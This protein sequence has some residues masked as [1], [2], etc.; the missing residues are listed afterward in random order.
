M[1]DHAEPF[2]GRIV[3]F[4]RRRL[5]AAGLVGCALAWPGAARAQTGENVL[6]VINTSQPASVKVGE[7]YATARRVP[8]NNVVRISAGTAELVSREDYERTIEQ[9]IGNWLAR[10]SLQ[11]K[12]LYLV[13]AKGVPLRISGTSGRD[14][15]E[16]SVDSELTLLYRKLAGIRTA[17]VGRVENPY[18]LN[19][20][21]LSEAKPFTRFVADIYLVTR[22]DGFTAEDAIK[23]IDRAQAPARNGKI[24]LDQP[25]E[26]TE[27]IGDKWVIEAGDRIK[28]LLGDRLVLETTPAPASSAAPV[29]GFFSWGSNDPSNQLRRHNLRFAN[30]AI[31]ATFVSTD[32]RT[33]VEPAD[34]WVPGARPGADSESLAA[35]LVREG[36]TGVVANVSE[37]YLEATARPQI[38]FPAYLTGFNLAESFYLSMPYLGW[39]T[40]V[41][42]DPLCAP[43]QQTPLRRADIDKGMDAET[44]LPALF[45]ERQLARLAESGLN[46]EGLKI[47]LRA[48]ARLARDPGINVEP[49]L[50]R[51][52]EI[53]PK[54]TVVNL[55][56]AARHEARAEFDQAIEQYRAVIAIEPQNAIALNN[57]AYALAERKQ[58]PKE[59]LPIAQKAYRLAQTPDVADTVGWIHHL[60][61]DDESALPWLERAAAAAPRS[62]EILI[63]AAVVHAALSD[64]T[65]ARQELQAAETLDPRIATRPDVQQLRARLKLEI[66]APNS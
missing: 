3:R 25:G 30:G 1:R 56:L 6:V 31:A 26:S 40:I 44:E 54:L 27:R 13:L 8:G 2:P 66:V 32:G 50:R 46:V 10:H 4:T 23:L 7:Y 37:P 55:R 39:Q 14:G 65:K 52:V 28:E 34:T 36:L 33:F 19:Q 24:V 20:G 58:L 41:I 17:V 59:A 38:F 16:S 49:L 48:D 53:E 35:D 9:P 22:L 12:V 29:L 61:G 15:T 57:L 60:L 62:V 11:D 18:Y 43:F 5:L 63:H 42:G 45:A 64:L 21:A 47:L 51:A